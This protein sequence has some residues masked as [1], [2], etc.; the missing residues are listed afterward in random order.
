MKESEVQSGLV[1]NTMNT[2]PL[3]AV[4][5]VLLVEDD[6]DHAELI[7]RALEGRGHQVYLHRVRDGE[8]ATQFLADASDG[9]LAMISVILVDLRL[10][11]KSGLELLREIKAHPRTSNIPAVVLTS[12]KAKNDIEEAYR[13]HANSYVLKPLGPHGFEGLMDEISTYWVQRNQRG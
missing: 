3:A 8:A 7:S 13:A 12:S 5:S 11:K 9:L 4:N 2:A 6:D 10:P 1:R